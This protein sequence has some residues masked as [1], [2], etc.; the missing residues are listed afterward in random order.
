[1]FRHLI[2]LL[3]IMTVTMAAGCT[4]RLE[5]TAV[6]DQ[7][8][9]S[10]PQI[11]SNGYEKTSDDANSTSFKQLDY[12]E[13]RLPEP[14]RIGYESFYFDH[15]NLI[16]VPGR[17]FNGREYSVLL[18]TG[19]PGYVLTNSLT[20][21]ENKLSVLPLGEAD[22]YSAHM[23]VCEVPALYIGSAEIVEP[24][25][26]YV[27]MQWEVKVVGLPV[28]R[29]K[30]FLIGLGMLRNFSYVG[31]DN[32]SEEV[33]LSAADAFEP[34][35]PADWDSYPLKIS[36]DK[37]FVE[38]PFYGRTMELM[39]DTCGRYGMIVGEKGFETLGL[40]KGSVDIRKTTFRSGFLGELPCRKARI[41]NLEIANLKIPSA[42]LIILPENSPYMEAEN[43]I[44]MK[45]F[46]N[47][48]VV[49]DFANERMWVRK[50]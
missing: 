9:L 17:L 37:L 24:P 27:Q 40:D 30:G 15:I 26:M 50:S 34:D 23:G 10:L 29:Q 13:I 36:D 45:F 11:N 5:K 1:M 12:S 48:T 47:T 25:C 28:W 19:F 39:F 18:D 38:M 49:L 16:A 8:L 7:K 21:L 4:I 14:T 31:F 41:K 35:T 44:S 42:E 3:L 32:V 43:S 6:K 2:R 20:V 46:R 22:W 33:E